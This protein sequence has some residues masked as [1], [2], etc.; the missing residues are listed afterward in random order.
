MT[1]DNAFARRVRGLALTVVT[2]L[3]IAS[4][5]AQFRMPEGLSPEQRTRFEPFESFRINGVC[6]VRDLDRLQSFGVNAVRGYTIPSA[7]EM[8]EQLDDVHSRG[9]KL[10][11]SE[12]MPHHGENKANNGS[13]YTFDYEA[14]GDRMVER[15]IEKVEGIGDHP[16]ILM[17]GLGNEVH[18]DPE[19]LRVANRMSE[20]IHERF[21]HHV[22]SLT[23]VNAKP[24]HIELVKTHAP[25][26]DVIGMQSY[27]V[28]AVRGHIRNL[29]QHWGKPFYVSEFNGKGPWNFGKTEWG[30]AYDETVDRKVADLRQCY[31]IID[32][33]PLCLGSTVFVWGYFNVNRATY[34]SLLLD[35][36]PNGKGRNASPEGLLMTPQAEVVAE[37]F[38]GR[39]FEGNRAPVLNAVAFA[40]DKRDLTTTPGGPVTV[41]LGSTDADGDE[42]R[43]TIWVLDSKP[44]RPKAVSGP[45]EASA[46]GT[47]TFKAPNKAGEYLVMA[48]V[49]DDN[50]GASASTLPLRVQR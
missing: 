4:A 30:E 37:H 27:S 3:F 48:Y 18:L 42:T 25:D 28:G 49:F 31:E 8:L 19:Y 44:N 39:P 9:M 1:S 10:V 24:E 38:T 12:W 29:E 26:I 35:E 36:H 34:F 2:S 23:M 32:E 41:D 43:Y 15:F 11:V 17:W 21:P 40:D 14:R 20:A 47:V 16:A 13:T 46:D 5:H 6:G 50:G 7:E 45:F 22:T 33:S